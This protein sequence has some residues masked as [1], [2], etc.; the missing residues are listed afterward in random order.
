MSA[1]LRRRG[2][3]R[4]RRRVGGPYPT[5]NTE[6]ETTMN[7]TPNGSAQGARALDYLNE[8]SEPASIDKIATALGITNKQSLGSSLSLLAQKGLIRRVHAGVYQAKLD[9][10]PA[11]KTEK[12]KRVVTDEDFFCALEM[13]GVDAVSLGNIVHVNAWIEQTRGLIE[14]L[15]SDG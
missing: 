12:P 7:R 8:H 4:P 11:R 15:N 2:H 5:P 10:V 9:V 3:K 13:L 14:R 6:T 1:R